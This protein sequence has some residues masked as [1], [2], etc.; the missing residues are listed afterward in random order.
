MVGVARSTF[1]RNEN[2]GY[3]VYYTEPPCSAAT[4]SSHRNMWTQHHHF[5]QHSR[6]WRASRLHFV[7]DRTGKPHCRKAYAQL[8][9]IAQIRSALMLSACKTLVYAQV[10][11]RLDFGNAALYGITGTLLH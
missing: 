4:S 6:P 11:S 3:S 5:G 7:D 10:K 2:R 1:E 9:F 8:R